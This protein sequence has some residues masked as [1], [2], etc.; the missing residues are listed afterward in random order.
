MVVE[1][2]V[3]SLRSVCAGNQHLIRLEK[4]YM[5]AGALFLWPIQKKLST[6]RQRSEF[7]VLEKVES[8]SL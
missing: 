2:V 3:I 6:S 4:H 7:G 5:N 1:Y 8:A